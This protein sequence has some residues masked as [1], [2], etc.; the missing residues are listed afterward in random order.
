MDIKL[1]SSD[2]ANSPKQKRESRGI[3]MFA[4]LFMAVNLLTAIGLASAWALDAGVLQER[5]DSY[6]FYRTDYYDAMGE[7]LRCICTG[8][9][10]MQRMLDREEK[11]IDY[12]ISRKGAVR[13]NLTA[14]SAAEAEKRLTDAP[15]E[16]SR[17]L[18]LR[19]G[20]LTDMK[21][22]NGLPQGEAIVP[23]AYSMYNSQW[24]TE[25]M[26][27]ITVCI[28]VK[29]LLSD[30]G[31]SLLY[32]CYELWR[33]EWAVAYGVAAAACICLLII[34]IAL[35]RRRAMRAFHRW[36]G[37][38]L[39]WFWLEVKL[40]FSLFYL[41]ALWVSLCVADSGEAIVLT[42]DALLL[43]WWLY[44]AVIDL[45][46]NRRRVF[47]R[48][49]LT[50]LISQY[51][52]LESRYGFLSKM[53]KRMTA[54]AV[55]EV[56]L[57]ASVM[58]AIVLGVLTID[59]PGLLFFFWGMLC[60]ALGVFLLVVFMLQYNRD[61]DDLGQCMSQMEQLQT[62]KTPPPLTLREKSDFTLLASQLNTLQ[63]GVERALWQ[64]MKSESMRVELITNVSHDLKTPLTSIINYIDLL[65]G[66]EL[67]PDYANDYVKIL[68]QK[69]NRLKL[70]VQDLFDISKASSGNM[71]VVIERLDLG[72]L[73]EQTMA[74]LGEKISASGL[75]FRVSVPEHKAEV[76]ADGR[77]LYRVLSNLIL[78][79]LKYAMPGTRVYLTVEEMPEQTTLVIKNI[80]A[81]EMSFSPEDIVE[82]FRRG[83]ESRATEGSGLGLAIVKSFLEIM[84]GSFRVELDGDLF[85][86][87]VTLKRQ[88]PSA[89]QESAPCENGFSQEEAPTPGPRDREDEAALQE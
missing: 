87:I 17:V 56:L 88:P 35:F 68:D 51:R 31:E 57:A 12:Y 40:A 26:E 11:N 41:G 49:S 10:N 80:S 47:T 39:G 66:E 50:W 1:K 43:F 60:A 54:V 67:T 44:F 86:A 73:I 70:L 36:A 33:A 24:A 59:G 8:N 82:R 53:K 63:E 14:Q 76:A 75:E 15:G 74:E 18:L 20:Q 2:I 71:E 34:L 37:R 16:Y 64:R 7:I 89:V 45:T 21:N 65:S 5:Y 52:R 6:S 38:I 42:A 58:L 27:D 30:T 9:P 3:L 23:L 61:M 29:A 32:Q 55:A 72:S 4:L 48:N 46:Q 77:K 79:A 13:T 78:N 28:G 69:A 19:S 85:K 25:D 84:G 62:G 22:E 83:D 81:C